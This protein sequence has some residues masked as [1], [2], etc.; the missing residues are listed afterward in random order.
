LTSD[1]GPSR[2]S[3]VLVLQIL[4]LLDEDLPIQDTRAEEVRIFSHQTSLAEKTKL[5]ES[6]M[7]RSI[8]TKV[9]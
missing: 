8:D 1:E 5:K 6:S 3:G 7:Q 9:L 2:A 4:T